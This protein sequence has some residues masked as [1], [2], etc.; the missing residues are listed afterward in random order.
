MTK[1]GYLSSLGRLEQREYLKDC[2]IV[3]AYDGERVA[4]GE[5][6]VNE[7]DGTPS[8]VHLWTP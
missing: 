1:G 8:G 5:V 7:D 6:I 3:A 2:M 4:A